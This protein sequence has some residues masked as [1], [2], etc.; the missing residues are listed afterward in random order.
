MFN[1]KEGKGYTPTLINVINQ[2][3]LKKSIC[4]TEDSAFASKIFR[5]LQTDKGRLLSP[6]CSMLKLYL[7]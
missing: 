2:F 4:F 3:S 1:S 7:N 5:H 6:G